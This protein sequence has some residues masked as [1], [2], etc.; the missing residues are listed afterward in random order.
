MTEKTF[1]EWK[2]E[3]RFLK[4]PAIEEAVKMA[5]EY[6]KDKEKEIRKFKKNYPEFMKFIDIL[7][8]RSEPT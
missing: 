2:N 7:K 4:V 8:N 6:Y 5:N 3:M 1:E